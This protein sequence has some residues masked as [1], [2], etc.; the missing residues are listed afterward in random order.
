MM[1][2][3]LIFLI[4][5][6]V[7]LSNNANAQGV[8]ISGT[9]LPTLSGTTASIGGSLLLAGACAAGT[10]TV[11][12][13]TTSMAATASPS[14]DPD[15][16]LST[17]AAIY[18]FVSSSNTVTVRICAIVSVTPASTTYNVRVIQ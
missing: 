3:L 12:G 2:F 15:S 17:G 6:V 16:S 8:S 5:L 10:A 4:V 7:P 9:S 18:A 1:R 13:A 11:A 14:S